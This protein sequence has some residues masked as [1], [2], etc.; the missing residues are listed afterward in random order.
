MSNMNAV[1]KW[2][3]IYII[4]QDLYNSYDV[5]SAMTRPQVNKWISYVSCLPLK[6]E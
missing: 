3:S 5:P 1:T 2:N 6:D 4:T